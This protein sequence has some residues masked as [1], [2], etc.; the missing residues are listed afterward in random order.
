MHTQSDLFLGVQLCK[1]NV[2]I[3]LFFIEALKK[4]IV[5]MSGY[6]WKI[7]QFELYRI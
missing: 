2:Y 3:S 5:Y 6:V 1:T 4:Q 7:Y